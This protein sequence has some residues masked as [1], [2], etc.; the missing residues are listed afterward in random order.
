MGLQIQFRLA[1]PRSRYVNITARV[2]TMSGQLVR[3]ITRNEAFLK[4]E[5]SAGELA[6]LY[7]DGYTDGGR[8]ARNGRYLIHIIAEDSQ[9]KKEVIKS[10]VLM[11]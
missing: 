2:Y 7:W 1:T 5:Y 9:K 8:M 10:I 3:E 11:K 6:A 4:G